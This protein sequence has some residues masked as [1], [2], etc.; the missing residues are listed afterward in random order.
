MKDTDGN[1]GW[2]WWVGITLFIFAAGMGGLNSYGQGLPPDVEFP[3]L[4]EPEWSPVLVLTGAVMQPAVDSIQAMLIADLDNDGRGEIVL[5]GD[6]IHRYF[7]SEGELNMGYLRVSLDIDRS[8]GP[9]REELNVRAMTAGDLNGDGLMDLVV[10]TQDDKLL[11]ISNHGRLGFQLAP[12]SPYTVAAEQVWLH[13]HDGDGIPDVIT[14]MSDRV[15]VLLGTGEGRLAEPQTVTGFT[16]L[17]RTGVSG[18]YAGTSGFFVLTREGLWFIPQQA[19]EAQ[20]VLEPGA[21]DRGLAIADFDNDGILDLAVGGWEEVRVYFGSSD[22]WGEPVVIEITHA[23]TWLSTGDLNEDGLAD[24]VAGV[25]SPGG[26]SGIYNLGEGKFAGAIRYGVQDPVMGGLPT[27]TTMGSVGDL[28]GD[29]KDEVTIRT[30]FHV[31]VYSPG[32][33]GRALLPIPGSFLLGVA[34]VNGDGI[35][36]LLSSTAQGGVAAL[37]SSSHRAFAIEG[38]VGPSGSNRTPYIAA[39]GDVTGDEE[40]ELVVFELADETYTFRVPKDESPGWEWKTER[41][42]ARITA[43]DLTNRKVLWSVPV[44]L[45]MRPLLSLF[46]LDGDGIKDAVTAVGDNVVWV[47]YDPTAVGLPM[48]L[49][50]QRAE[51]NCGGPVGP[52]ALVGLSHG[53]ALAGLRLSERSELFLILDGEVQETGVALEIAPLDMISADMNRDGNDDLIVIGWGVQS[54]GDEPQLAIQLAILFGDGE[55]SFEPRIFSIRDW[56]PLSMPFPYGGLTVGDL[57]GDGDL[58]LACMRLPDQEGNP[59]GVMVIPWEGDG[60]GEPVLIEGCVGTK[61][62]ALDIDGDGQAELVS[63]QLGTPAQLCLTTWR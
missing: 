52:L 4:F 31:A 9:G 2:A 61:L 41:S 48:H 12:G 21:R 40:L 59:G 49:R 47:D 58:D 37:L 18:S 51:I 15:R 35:E 1:R 19:T 53:N 50:A 6:Y 55:G 11:V 33:K 57:D 42:K 3:L 39:F 5:G 17:I 14:G 34:D 24:L 45:E 28:D 44:G 13:D 36:D 60:L 27:T 63:V 20:K 26:F 30:N 8:V 16:G 32:G 38:L 29:G 7:L 56:P 22:G 25:F 23:V 54:V 62:F 43:W 10:A 46:D